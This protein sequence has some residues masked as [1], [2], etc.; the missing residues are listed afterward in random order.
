MK[1]WLI[2]YDI[3]DDKRRYH[4]SRLLEGYGERVQLSAFE[5]RLTPSHFTA[6][7]NALRRIVGSDDIVHYYSVCK[8]CAEKRHVQGSAELTHSQ[9]YYL[10]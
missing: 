2:C 10:T 7:R 1:L 8:W 6:L 4:V 5:C 3:S 9:A